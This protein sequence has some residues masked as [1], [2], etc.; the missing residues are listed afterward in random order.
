MGSFFGVTI[1]TIKTSIHHPNADRLNVCTLEGMNYQFVTARDE[2]KPGDN[3]L[4]FPLDAVLPQ[5]LLKKMGLEGRLAGKEKNRIKTMRLRGEISQGIVGPLSLINPEEMG[6]APMATAPYSSEELTMYFGV[7]KY[8]PPPIPCQNGTLVS[9]PCGLHEY[10]IESA[11][12]YNEVVE[13]VLM[14]QFVSITEKIEGMNFSVTWDVKHAQGYVNQRNF[15]IIPNKEGDKHFFW[16]TA[17]ERKILELAQF[18]AKLKNA[19]DVS[20]YGE[21]VGPGSQGNYYGLKKNDVP[22]FD[23]KVDGRFIPVDEF[24]NIVEQAGWEIFKKSQGYTIVP[25]IAHDVLLRNWLNGRTL[26]QASTDKS[27]WNN[28]KLREGIVIK[29]KVE[30]YSPQ[31]K[32]RLI[33]K[34]HS[35]E[36]LEK[37]SL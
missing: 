27:R 15:S 2:F 37:S 24:Y 16:R 19:D 35:P 12:R 36:Y 31:L 22:L 10:D 32:G 30:Q 23:I 21:L 26:R 9:L 4:Y 1:E 5:E 14:D 8:D 6:G 18:I 25:L 28:D 13:Q 33:I 29:P 3:V 7:T 17:E 20:V 34:Q 11:D